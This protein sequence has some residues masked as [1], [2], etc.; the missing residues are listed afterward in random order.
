MTNEKLPLSCL[1][2]MVE[3]SSRLLLVIATYCGDQS[4]FNI[5][6]GIKIIFTYC[7]DQSTPASHLA[8]VLEC[9]A[10]NISGQGPHR[11]FNHFQDQFLILSTYFNLQAEGVPLGYRAIVLGCADCKEMGKQPTYNI[12]KQEVK[13]PSGP[14][15]W[16]LMIYHNLRLL[17]IAPPKNID[18]LHCPI[19][20]AS[21]SPQNKQTQQ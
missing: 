16:E 12:S 6:I 19:S 5:N 17:R 11:T 8:R 20:N 13:S 9:P 2:Q 1:P 18:C 15:F 3:L 14:Q 7:G 4:I 10:G 21:P